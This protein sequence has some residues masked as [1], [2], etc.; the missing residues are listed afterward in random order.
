MKFGLNIYKIYIFI[1]VIA[2]FV[3]F[4]YFIYLNSLNLKYNIEDIK[5]IY[6]VFLNIYK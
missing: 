2:I 5:I 3:L 4:I 6:D 1:A